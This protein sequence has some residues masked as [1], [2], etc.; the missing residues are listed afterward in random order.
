MYYTCR[1]AHARV[2]IGPWAQAS[3]WGNLPLDLNEAVLRHLPVS[4]YW[5]A[6]LCF[7]LWADS[8]SQSSFEV[9]PSSTLQDLQG[10]VR[11]LQR[12]RRQHQTTLRFCLQVTQHTSPCLLAAVLETLSQVRHAKCTFCLSIC[13]LLKSASLNCVYLLQDQV[14]S[15]CR[16]QVKLV[17]ANHADSRRLLS[18]Y[19]KLIASASKALHAFHE[20]KVQITLCSSTD[21]TVAP[22]PDVLQLLAPFITQVD[23]YD[24]LKDLTSRDRADFD[25]I[26]AAFTP[27]H[28]AALQ[29]CSTNLQNLS[30]SDRTQAEDQLA[31]LVPSM[32]AIATF[33]SL[34]KLHLTLTL[35]ATAADFGPLAQLSLLEDLALQCPLD[36]DGASCSG[37]L[38]SSRATLRAVVLK[39]GSWDAE[40]YQSL[41]GSAQLDKVCIRIRQLW[42]AA[43]SEL[44][45]IKARFIQLVIME[46]H[47][48]SCRAFRALT[49]HKP[50]IRE[51]VCYDMPDNLTVYLQ[52]MPH[53]ET[54]YLLE[55]RLFTGKHLQTHTTLKKFAIRHCDD[56]VMIVD[57]GRIVQKL[58][59]LELLQL[60]SVCGQDPDYI[61]LASAKKLQVLCLPGPDML[62]NESMLRLHWA[63]HKSQKEDKAQPYVQVYTD[64]A[65]PSNAGSL[66]PTPWTVFSDWGTF[67]S[68]PLMFEYNSDAGSAVGEAPHTGAVIEFEK[69]VQPVTGQKY[70]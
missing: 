25:T 28:I 42:Y 61:E 17:I 69:G 24:V 48:C 62:S 43:A 58:P 44:G 8:A 5:N 9:A 35:S 60:Q 52:Q 22:A 16:L 29:Q 37:V 66:P 68:V 34:T 70:L 19:A 39:A 67:L 38:S 46:L 51:L 45:K 1:Y 64:F 55:A 32:S 30:I 15:D 21:A 3:S 56:D 57:L 23:Y 47:Q 11:D 49:A 53:L 63:F 18:Q 65:A 27:S 10:V 41:Q 26:N 40:T 2:S 50:C 20:V 13:I 36:V 54:L 31:T 33:T 14:L 7:P 59:A 12:W 6:F 4:D